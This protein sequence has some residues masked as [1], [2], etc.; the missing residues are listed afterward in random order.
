MIKDK[1]SK[2]DPQ[3]YLHDYHSE[4]AQDSK[5]AIKFLINEIGILDLLQDRS[6]LLDVGCGPTLYAT[7][8]L[9]HLFDEIYLSDY[10]LSNLT[11][12]EAWIKKQNGMFDWR[13][14]TKFILEE[15]KGRITNNKEIEAHEENIRSRIRSLLYC[16]VYR[17]NP[18]GLIFREK[19]PVV[20]TMFC[21]DSITNNQGDWMLMMNNI[22]SLV[23]PN[24]MLIIGAL[25]DC[26]SYIVGQN[27]FPS[28][29]IS[30]ELIQSY[31]RNNNKYSTEILKMEVFY[32][33]ENKQ[34]GYN[35]IALALIKK[36]I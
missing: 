3:A 33:P 35:E 21:P 5:F 11:Q 12:I 30:S 26:S 27:N 23:A 9:G 8:A 6:V 16:D 32:V 24:G 34:L 36:N 20:M 15:E 10:L 25:L 29:N 17:D 7:L 4:V 28:A 1:W 22:L 13:P 31:F 19:F 14:H 18:I 2:W